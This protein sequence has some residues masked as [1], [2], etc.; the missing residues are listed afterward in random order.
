VTTTPDDRTPVRGYPRAVL[1][2]SRVESELRGLA[3]EAHDLEKRIR[4]AWSK[5]YYTHPDTSARIIPSQQDA[6]RRMANPYVDGLEPLSVILHGAA[7]LWDETIRQLMIE[8]GQE[9]S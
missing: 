4:E 8:S 2:A 7:G 9:E 6:A 1:D 3:I 5:A